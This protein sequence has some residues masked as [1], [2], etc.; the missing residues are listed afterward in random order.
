M[1]Y[2]EFDNK[3]L[4]INGDLTVTGKLNGSSGTSNIAQYIKTDSGRSNAGIY[5]GQVDDFKLANN[6][7]PSNLVIGIGAGYSLMSKPNTAIS[8]Y[9]NDNNVIIGNHAGG[10]LRADENANGGMA[11]TL[12]VLVGNYVG[13]QMGAKSLSNIFIGWETARFSSASDWGNKLEG[14]VAIGGR[15]LQYAK[16]ANA[17]VVLGDNTFNSSTNVRSLLD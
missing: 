15:A 5:I 16:K 7:N 14:N 8:G 10:Y 9:N 12:N 2:G 6:N 3:K 13:E 11:A 1:I 17:N 4:T